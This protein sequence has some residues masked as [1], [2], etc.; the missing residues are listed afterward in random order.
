ML[1]P[2]RRRQQRREGWAQAVRRR[3][4]VQL[5]TLQRFPGAAG[6]WRWICL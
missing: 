4:R 6:R 2:L 5:L 3:P 1:K